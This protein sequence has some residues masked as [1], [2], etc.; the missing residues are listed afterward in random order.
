MAPMTRLYCLGKAESRRRSVKALVKDKPLDQLEWPLGLRLE[1]REIPRNLDPDEVLLKVFAAGICGTDVGIYNGKKPLRDEMR[2]AR[3]SS[4][5]IGHEFAG[6]IEKAGSEALARLAEIVESHGHH[7][8]EIERF[9]RGRTFRQVAADASFTDF[10]QKYYHVSA[11]MHIT[12]GW[13]YQCRLGQR[14]VCRNTI[15]KGVHEDGAFAEYVKVPVS[16]LILFRAGELPVSVIA[17]M[18][19]LGNAVHTVQSAKLLGQAVVILGCGNQ[20]LMATAIAHRSGATRIYVTDVSNEARGATHEKLDKNRF[21]LA[22]EFGANDCF[23]LAL[24]EERE[25]LQKTVLRETDGSGV[26]VALE[27]S[28]SYSAYRDAFQLLR[29]GGTFVLLGIPEGEMKLDF[30]RDVI[31]KGLT[32][33]GVIGRRVFETWETMRNMLSTGLAEILVKSGFITEL[34]FEQ[35]DTA[36]SAMVSGDAFKVILK[37]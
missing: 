5:I 24:P 3:A 4:V 7:D 33:H 20:G 15:I 30:A 11:E 6:R 23:D 34:P 27:M 22:R 9:V 19:A 35:Y 21:A 37:L 17:F 8:S 14:H 25:R 26:D 18:D 31:F 10:L 32:I 36:M 2:K 28:G 12:C 13:C 29:M 1:D 16:N